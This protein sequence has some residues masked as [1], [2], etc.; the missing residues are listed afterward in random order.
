MEQPTP[1]SVV[2]ER[3]RQAGASQNWDAAREIVR[4]LA[5]S[6]KS[7]TEWIEWKEANSLEGAGRSLGRDDQKNLAKCLS[8]FANSSGGLI[9]WGVTDDQ[10]QKPFPEFE[11][12]LRHQMKLV[13]SATLPPISGIEA[14]AVPSAAGSTRGY[15]VTYVPRSDGAPHQVSLGVDGK[16]IYFGRFG[17]ECKHLDHYS[18]SDLFGRRPGPVFSFAERFAASWKWVPRGPSARADEGEHNILLEILIDV[19]NNGAVTA[20][21]VYGSVEWPHNH[22]EDVVFDEVRFNLA[23]SLSCKA[24]L[25]NPETGDQQST[26]PNT[27]SLVLPN[28]LFARHML[29]RWLSLKL[30]AKCRALPRDKMTKAWIIGASAS[31]VLQRSANYLIAADSA[32]AVTG[33]SRWTQDLLAQR[34]PEGCS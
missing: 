28:P 6:P 14:L 23:W 4:Y 18:I 1:A 2:F 19:S 10:R 25:L 20:H 17:S 30:L 15:V 9:V 13:A 32:R 27:H 8:A 34:L 7:E 26:R 33:E 21:N 3:L 24:R 29:Q 5:E 16:G 11:E 22:H 31:F 12:H